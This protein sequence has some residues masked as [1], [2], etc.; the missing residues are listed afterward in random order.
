[1]TTSDLCFGSLG[2]VSAVTGAA[3]AVVVLVVVV[4]VIAVDVGTSVVLPR[5][6]SSAS[7]P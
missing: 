3:A 1:M 7:R 2:L 4:V 6:T 5:L